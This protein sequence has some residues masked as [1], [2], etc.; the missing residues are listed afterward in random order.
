MQELSTRLEQL[1]A[2][3]FTLYLRVLEAGG[4]TVSLGPLACS[5]PQRKIEEG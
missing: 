5:K 1:A 2:W 4:P 3:E